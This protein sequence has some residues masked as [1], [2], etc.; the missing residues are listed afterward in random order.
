[1]NSEVKVCRVKPMMGE[2]VETDEP[3][4]NG[5]VRYSADNW[6]VILG[7]SYETVFQCEALE[8][9]YRRYRR[10]LVDPE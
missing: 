2:F 1:M 5:Y 3:D 9:A 6:M 4:V 10:P 7:E 8:D